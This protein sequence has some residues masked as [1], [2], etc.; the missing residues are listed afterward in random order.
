MQPSKVKTT[1]SRS[2]EQRLPNKY[3]LMVSLLVGFVTL[4]AYPLLA[5]L[6][7]NVTKDKASVIQSEICF[8]ALYFLFLLTL[9]CLLKDKNNVPIPAII[10]IPLLCFYFERMASSIVYYRDSNPVFDLIILSTL[11]QLMTILLYSAHR[12][13]YMLFT[14]WA[15]IIGIVFMLTS[16]HAWNLYDE[17][18]LKPLKGGYY[19]R[20]H[21]MEAEQWD[22]YISYNQTAAVITIAALIYASVHWKIRLKQF[23][24]TRKQRAI[25]QTS[26][27]Q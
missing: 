5:S 14:F 17:Q 16:I 3:D 8:F 24:Q 4:I 15:W 12:V 20:F 19:Y 22:I 1:N 25:L 26:K 27:R 7:F 18:I 9:R 13:Y 2:K 6:I 23:L 11:M 10:F 21:M